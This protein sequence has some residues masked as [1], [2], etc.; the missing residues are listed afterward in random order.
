MNI[1]K[2]NDGYF[3]TNTYVLWN[4]EQTIIIDCGMDAQRI[5]DEVERT[6]NPLSAILI[7]H[8]HFDHIMTAAQIRE[9]T[10]APIYISEADSEKT[11]DNVK[12]RGADFGISA[13]AFKADKLLKDGDTLEFCGKSFKVIATPGHSEGSICFITENHLF[14]GDTLF[15]GT[16]GR[17]EREDK[18]QMKASVRKLLELPEDTNIYPGHGDASTIKFE[19]RYNPFAD[20]DWEWE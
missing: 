18:P 17:F 7:T 1:K 11:D 12:N 4:S 5:L 14:C 13:P 9:K 15:K 16:I 2:V 20:F 8:G 19:K 3:D 10:G 6:G